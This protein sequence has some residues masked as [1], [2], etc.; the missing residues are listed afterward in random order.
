M[1]KV[2]GCWVF[3]VLASV[4]H[5]LSSVVGMQLVAT[6]GRRVWMIAA[7]SQMAV[8]IGVTW[9]FVDLGAVAGALGIAV[10][11]IV[12]LSISVAHLRGGRLK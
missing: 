5:A 10:G 11:A 12:S 6:D 7:L 4:P 8:A 1:A 3:F 2:G 9:V